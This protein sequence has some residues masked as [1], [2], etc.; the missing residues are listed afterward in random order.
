M[1]CTIGRMALGV[2]MLVGMMSSPMVGAKSADVGVVAFDSGTR[3]VREVAEAL[4]GTGRSILESYPRGSEI[5]LGIVSFLSERGRISAIEWGMRLSLGYDA[6]RASKVSVDALA[7]WCVAQYPGDERYPVI[8]IGSPNGAVAHLAS[9][10]GAPFLTTSFGLA[11][12]HPTINPD[13]SDAYRQTSQAVAQQV[14]AGNPDGNYEIICHYDPI[15]DRSMVRVADFI[16]VK[17]LDLPM[18]YRD[19]I[20]D[21]LTPDGTLVLINCTYGWPQISLGQGISLQIGGLGAIEPADYLARWESNEQVGIHRES[22]WGCPEAFADAVVHYAD[23][24]AIRFL[25]IER[26]HPAEYSLLAHSAYLACDNVRSEALL[27][28]SF[29]HLNPRTNIETGIPGLWL[30]FNTSDG[31]ALVESALRGCAI[32]T[33]YFAPLPSF[34]QSPD[35]VSLDTWTELISPIGTLEWVGVRADKY[36]ADPLAPF[37]FVRDMNL[38]RD[39]FQQ[40][41]PLRLPIET[42]EAL[43]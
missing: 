15:H 30:P 3:V 42:L 35:T 2:I 13:D 36:P 39:T 33:V 24:H 6:D 19:F 31:L 1:K 5:F 28:D 27:I 43:L 9:L 12:R 21:R 34:V 4:T 26:D 16:R 18:S 17:L 10:L 20:R 14:I 37:R 41:A 11:F 38:L 29:N 32:D 23:T 7:E 8:V 25:E 22:E 40:G